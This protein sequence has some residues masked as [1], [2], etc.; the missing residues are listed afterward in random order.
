MLIS[1]IVAL[2]LTP[3]LSAKILRVSTRES[4]F[5][6]RGRYRA[7]WHHAALRRTL[8]RALRRPSIVIAGGAALIAA[9]RSFSSG[10]WSGSS[11]RRTIVDSS[12]RS[13]SRLKARRSAYTDEY[14]RQLEAIVAEHEGRAIDLRGHRIRGGRPTP[15]SSAPFSTDFDERDR[16]GAGHH[17]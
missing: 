13:S 11:C 2:T 5:S 9:A 14:L 3:M 10:R 15:V 16:V 17:R 7:R 8:G 4:R 6:P 1:G 12:S